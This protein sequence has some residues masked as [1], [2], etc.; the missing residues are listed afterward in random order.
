M[1]LID[2]QAL[3]KRYPLGRSVVVK[4]LRGVDLAVDAGEVLAILGRSGSG[5]STLMNLIGGLDKPTAGSLR[6]ADLELGRLPAKAL[7]AFRAETIGFVFQSFH[8]QPRF[9]A[10]ENVALPLTFA[11]V[12]RGERKRRATAVL[13][14]VGLADRADHRPSQ[15]SGGEQQRVALARAL[16]SEPPLLLCDEPTGNLDS[17]TSETILD[18]L[19]EARAKGATLVMVTHD[20]ELAQEHATRIVR[21]GDGRVASDEQN[22][23]R[24]EVRA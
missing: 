1:P 22:T 3:E 7:A 19:M 12:S 10:W 9:H 13:E 23:P 16:V 18:L 8:L 5:K 24:R 6:V 17:R 4:A 14:R 20:D 11:G 2:A 21:M 15:L